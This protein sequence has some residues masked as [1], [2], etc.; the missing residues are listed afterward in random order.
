MTQD[1]TCSDVFF[2][3]DLT[4]WQQVRWKEP[5]APSQNN[6]N[7]GIP[8]LLLSFCLTLGGS[9]NF[10]GLYF[11]LIRDLDFITCV[12]SFKK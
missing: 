11:H 12:Q 1:S 8:A 2:S 5:W 9:L 10:S 6:S 7:P 3:G 4:G